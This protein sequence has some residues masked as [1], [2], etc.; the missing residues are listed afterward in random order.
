MPVTTLPVSELRANLAAVL[1]AVEAGQRIL[2]TR[3]DKIVAALVPPGADPP[4]PLEARA[5]QLLADLIGADAADGLPDVVQNPAID[6]AE[7]TAE[8]TAARR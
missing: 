2:L 4:S 5:A 7:W 8:I 3:H 1:T 6:P